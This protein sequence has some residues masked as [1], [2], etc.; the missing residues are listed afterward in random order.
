MRS[1]LKS[2]KLDVPDGRY[3]ISFYWAELESAKE[4][5]VSVYNLGNDAIA[6]NFTKRIFDVSINNLKVKNKL[7]ITEEFGERKAI[8]LKS[9]VDVNSG[10]GLD[11]EFDPI[12]GKTMLNAIRIYRNY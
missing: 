6:D 8:I 1:G 12:V 11:I 10:E 4:R 7:N 2:F 3:T 5:K 9:V